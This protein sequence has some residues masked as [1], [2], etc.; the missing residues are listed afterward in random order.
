MHPGFV[1]VELGESVFR[2]PL[3][4][5]L[6]SRV[7]AILSHPVFHQFDGER[8]SLCRSL[9]RQQTHRCQDNKS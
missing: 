5:E 8:I 7:Q 9:R 1:F 4:R 6:E 3:F 2:S